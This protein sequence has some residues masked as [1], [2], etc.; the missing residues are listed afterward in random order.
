MRRLLIQLIAALALVLLVELAFQAGIWEPLAKPA[1]HAGTSVRLKRA[2]TDPA[3]ARIDFVTLG[4]SRPEYGLDHETIAAA[5]KRHGFVHANASLAGS[6]WMTIGVLSRWL[7]RAHPEIR[8]GVIALSIADFE[9]A[10]NGS[11]ELGIVYPFHRLRDIPWM[12]RHVPFSRDDPETWGA[13]SALFGW[14]EDIRDFV[15][16]PEKRI[17]SLDWFADHNPMRKLF[18]NFASKGDMCAFGIESITACERVEATDTEAARRLAGQC[19][20]IRDGAT[21]RDAREARIRES[22][23]PEPLRETGPLVRR[24]L[25]AIPWAQPP[26]VVLMPMPR[27]WTVDVLPAS[28]HARALAILRPLVDAGRIRVIDATGFFAEDADG[29]CASFFDFYH[30]NASGRERFTRWLL[31]QLESALYRID[32]R[33]GSRP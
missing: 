4:S 26:V 1:S 18:E 28:L 13:F 9:Y 19:R 21:R 10:G 3:N 5:A 33:A 23:Q 11:Y 31:P 2:L 16:H 15:I 27:V 8:G 30:Q 32:A 20:M 7:A 25:R 24:T 6:H 17:D 14:R 12:M 29:G 22:P